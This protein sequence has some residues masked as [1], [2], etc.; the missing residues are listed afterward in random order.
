MRSG[1]HCPSI[2]AKRHAEGGRCYH[3]VLKG[4][5]ELDAR[6]GPSPWLVRTPHGAGCGRWAVSSGRESP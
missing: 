5:P 4:S 2:G 6:K 3:L 1:V